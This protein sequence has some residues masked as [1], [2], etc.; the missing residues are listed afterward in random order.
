M[1]FTNKKGFA[2]KFYTFYNILVDNGI[3]IVF[4]RDNNFNCDFSPLVL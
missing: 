3:A 2:L 4:S 1:Q